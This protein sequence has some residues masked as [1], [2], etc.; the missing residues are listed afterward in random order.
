MA[1]E[2]DVLAWGAEGQGHEPTRPSPREALGAGGR[3]TAEGLR[4]DRGPGWS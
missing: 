3:C 4:M 1:T 2:V